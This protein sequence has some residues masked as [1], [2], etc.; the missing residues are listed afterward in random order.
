MIKGLFMTVCSELP[1][2]P[3]VQ[4]KRKNLAQRASAF[5]IEERTRRNGRF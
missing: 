3:Q 4:E 5:V 2:Q 1:A